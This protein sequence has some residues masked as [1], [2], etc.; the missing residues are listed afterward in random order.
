MVKPPDVVLHPGKEHLDIYITSGK[1]SASHVFSV[2]EYPRALSQQLVPLRF[3]SRRSILSPP[4][5][6]LPKRTD[7]I[8]SSDTTEITLK[9]YL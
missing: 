3:R 8:H 2:R 9:R 1:N 4:M 6:G 5:R 7:R